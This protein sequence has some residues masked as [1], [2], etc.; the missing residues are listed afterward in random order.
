MPSRPGI[1]GTKIFSKVVVSK[2]H[3]HQVTGP[4]AVDPKLC[5]RNGAH[6]DP[7]QI[8][9]TTSEKVMGQLKDPYINSTTK[10]RLTE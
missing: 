10:R 4:S 5:H 1:R 8:G 7:E 3:R 9:A 2:I 6:R